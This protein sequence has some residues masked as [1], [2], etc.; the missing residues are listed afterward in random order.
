MC[1]EAEMVLLKLLK[2]TQPLILRDSPLLQRRWKK[3]RGSTENQYC[4]LFVI[5]IWISWPN[6]VAKQSDKTIWATLAMAL[7]LKKYVSSTGVSYCAITCFPG[8]Y[9]S[10]SSNKNQLATQKK[11]HRKK[12]ALSASHPITRD[13]IVHCHHPVSVESK[14]PSLLSL[15]KVAE[16]GQFQQFLERLGRKQ[17]ML[18]A[19]LCS[20]PCWIK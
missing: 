17:K 8:S 3:C 7:I 1:E 5:G 13:M 15:A 6:G 10:I 16:N 12:S 11:L 9:S 20:N 19:F 2:W 14:P 4:F 18:G